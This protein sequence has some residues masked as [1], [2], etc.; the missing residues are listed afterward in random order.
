LPVASSMAG[1]QYESGGRIKPVSR[2]LLTHYIAV[3][4]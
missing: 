1:N 2:A 4:P 3:N